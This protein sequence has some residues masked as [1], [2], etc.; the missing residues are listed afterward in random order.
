ML[1]VNVLEHTLRFLGRV[2]L[3]GDEV[4]AFVACTNALHEQRQIALLHAQSQASNTPAP[5][6]TRKKALAPPA[7]PST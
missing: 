7:P 2:T 4:P 1:D 5:K 6:P 3:Q